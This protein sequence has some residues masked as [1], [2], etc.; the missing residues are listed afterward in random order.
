MRRAQASV[1]APFGF[2]QLIWVTLAGYVVFGDF[3]DIYTITGAVIV[4]SSSIYVFY[5]ES[6]VKLAARE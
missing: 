4:V 6:V 3:P 5:R 1:L 2:I